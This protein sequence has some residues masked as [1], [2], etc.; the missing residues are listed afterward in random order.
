[1]NGLHWLVDCPFDRG[2][3]LAVSILIVLLMGQSLALNRFKPQTD[4][5]TLEREKERGRLRKLD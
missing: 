5:E 2:D 3:C 4:R 1:M